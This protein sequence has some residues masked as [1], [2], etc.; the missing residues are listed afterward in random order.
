[1]I[2]IGGN[3]E[4]KDMTMTKKER[5]RRKKCGRK[6]SRVSR[7]EAEEPKL[8]RVDGDGFFGFYAKAISPKRTSD[9]QLM[10]SS[11]ALLFTNFVYHVRIGAIAADL[12]YCHCSSY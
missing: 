12:I 5:K 7:E 3:K 11:L 1:M 4:E 9:A 8:S 6:H 2:E 10:P